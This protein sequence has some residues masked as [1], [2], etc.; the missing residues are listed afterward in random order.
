MTAFRPRFGFHPS[1]TRTESQLARGEVIYSADASLARAI[2]LDGVNRVL[3]V[4]SSSLS[5]A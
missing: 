3:G 5:V 4:P 1:L 2:G